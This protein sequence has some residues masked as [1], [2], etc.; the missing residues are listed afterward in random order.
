MSTNSIHKWIRGTWCPRTLTQLL[1]KDAS[2]D[3]TITQKH[4]AE[5]STKT[6][7]THPTQ[8]PINTS[9]TPHTLQVD[10][11]HQ[12]DTEPYTSWR[13][14]ADE[15]GGLGR[16]AIT[17]GLRQA[18]SSL[19]LPLLPT[20][21]T[22]VDGTLPIS[23][24]TNWQGMY[25]AWEPL[26]PSHCAREPPYEPL[27]PVK[28]RLASLQYRGWRVIEVPFHEWA[29][30]APGLEARQAYVTAKMERMRE[31]VMGGGAGV[32]RAK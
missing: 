16:P 17:T 20:P 14:R 25:L 30:L 27:G 7:C 11:L 21:T 12:P 4:K 2:N 31:E 18:L 32:I 1:Y 22:T 26:D 19:G 3:D 10:L 29:G 13:V 5:Y 8:Q 28:S 9:Y 15:P 6:Y 23:L 24:G